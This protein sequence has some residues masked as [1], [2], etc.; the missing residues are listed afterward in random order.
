MSFETDLER[1]LRSRLDSIELPAHIPAV[2]VHR[3]RR[4]RRTKVATLGF[5]AATALIA[6]LAL[7][8]VIRVPADVDIR[9][10]GRKPVPFENLPVGKATSTQPLVNSPLAPP[11]FPDCTQEMLEINS[12]VGNFGDFLEVGLRP[13]E[14]VQCGLEWWPGGLW[15]GATGQTYKAPRVNLFKFVSRKELGNPTR[16]RVLLMGAAGAQH[17]AGV[18]PACRLETPLTYSITLAE[19][20]V[21]V[22]TVDDTRCTP[23]KGAERPY[24]YNPPGLETPMAFLDPR[25]DAVERQTP[26]TLSFILVLT[27]DTDE[28][29]AVGRCPFYD[30]SYVTS[31]GKARLRSY[32]NCPAAPDEVR[33]GEAL[34]F[35][36]E[37]PLRD[38]GGPGKLNMTLR[39]ETRPLHK[40]QEEVPAP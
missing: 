22:G 3:S 29:I 40:L 39:D 1:A 25:I 4:R 32:L 27:N 20:A 2:V 33:P 11:E 18:G 35:S 9:P 37:L 16:G 30:V 23:G 19:E 8:G 13:R 24:V 7:V 12:R 36:I 26:D 5:G 17:S 34:R 14:G 6:G 31:E 28:P 38:L 21:E 15:T 10:A